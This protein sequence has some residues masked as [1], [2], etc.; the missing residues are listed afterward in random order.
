[1]MTRRDLLS[2]AGRLAL[3]AAVVSPLGVV[4]AL[5]QS[6]DVA[7]LM[8]PGPLEDIALGDP[9]APITVVEY[10]SMT[11]PHCAA[12]HATTFAELKERFIDTGQVYFILREFPL[13]PLASAG[14]ML[15]RCA[16]NGNYYPMVD[17]LFETQR[18]WTTAPDPSVAL[19]DLSK[20]VGFTQES[21]VACLTD[22][23]LL[24]GVNATRDRASTEF[25]VSSTPTFFI[26]GEK[27]TGAL[28]IEEMEEIFSALI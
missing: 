15:A 14:F 13:D 3:L 7:D 5:A 26:N 22:Q 2:S 1:M 16:P 11:C 4:G 17:L 9:N 24:D 8:A 25:G 10:A 6:V 21:F 28:T 19:S 18:T 27:H 12:F 20:Q 23:T